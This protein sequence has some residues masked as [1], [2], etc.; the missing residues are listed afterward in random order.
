MELVAEGR[1]C[2][3][4]KEKNRVREWSVN[5]FEHPSQALVVFWDVSNKAVFIWHNFI[6]AILIP[7]ESC[8]GIIIIDTI[9]II[10]AAH[11]RCRNE[12]KLQR[13]VN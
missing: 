6:T 4:E 13:W 1:I 12:E 7:I 11:P 3:L 8:I 9:L 2:Q 10:W 5:G